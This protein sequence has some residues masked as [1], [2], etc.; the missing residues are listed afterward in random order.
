MC[1]REEICV[2]DRT[3]GAFPAWSINDM[4]EGVYR[5]RA[6]NPDGWS[7]RVL[8]VD[9]RGSGWGRYSGSPIACRVGWLAKCQVEDQWNGYDAADQDQLQ[10]FVAPR[11]R[12]RRLFMMFPLVPGHDLNLWSKVQ[13]NL[14][15][16]KWM[17]HFEKCWGIPILNFGRMRDSHHNDWSNGHKS[18]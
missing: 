18:G 16:F 2:P 11:W 13:R 9:G 15:L 12:R 8:A 14:L 3:V 5:L 17:R 4:E 1:R 6:L 10:T 7:G